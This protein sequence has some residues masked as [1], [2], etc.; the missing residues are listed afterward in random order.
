MPYYKNP[1]QYPG[2]QNDEPGQFAAL[3]IIAII[4]LLLLVL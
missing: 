1:M 2:N 4:A 3:I